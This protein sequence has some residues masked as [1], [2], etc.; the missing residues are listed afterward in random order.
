MNANTSKKELFDQNRNKSGIYRWVNTVNGKT[1]I[2]SAVNLTKRLGSYFN[3]NELNR[4][5]SP[6]KKALLSY[7]HYKFRIDILEYC[8]KNSLL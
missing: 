7:G 5:S 3:L 4:N 6:I 1:Y 2:G 8:P